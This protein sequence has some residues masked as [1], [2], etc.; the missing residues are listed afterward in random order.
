MNILYLGN[1]RYS[2]WSLRPW[3]LA[4]KCGFTFSEQMVSLD[5]PAEDVTFQQQLPSHRVPMLQLDSGLKIWDS[6][7]IGEYLAELYPHLLPKAAD[8]RAICRSV[9]AEMHSG[10]QQ[11]RTHLHMNLGW[12]KD[13]QQ[14]NVASQDLQREITRIMEL[15]TD[16]KTRFGQHGPWLFGEFSLADAMFAPVV[17]RFAI[18]GIEQTGVVKDYVQHWLA[19]PDLQDWIAAALQETNTVARYEIYPQ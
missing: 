3:L 1:K 12:L 6:L 13:G 16:C 17:L 15:W 14:P 9:C 7:A 5:N 19:D 8:A 18:Y 2:S 10:F 11:L 4:R